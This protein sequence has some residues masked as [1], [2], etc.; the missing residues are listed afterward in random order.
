MTLQQIYYVLTISETGSMNQAAE[1]LFISQPAL[2][3]AIRELEEEVG[4]TIFNRSSRGVSETNEGTEFLTQARQLYQQYELMMEKYLEPGGIRRKFCVSAQH[5][6]FA[7]NA[8]VETVKRFD[9]LK[10]EYAIRETRTFD[11]ILDVGTSRSEIGI[12]YRN[13]FNRKM[14]EKYFRDY[15]LVFTPLV[16]C[17]P[18][19]YISR[20]HPLAQQKQITLK[21]LEPYPCLAFEQG[22][23]GSLFMAEELLSDHEYPRIIRACDRATMLNLMTGLNAYTLCSGIICQELNGDDFLAIPFAAPEESISAEMEIGYITRK[24]SVPSELGEAYLEEMKRYLG[25]QEALVI[26]APEAGPSQKA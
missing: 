9:L 8:F 12:L 16:K 20:Q 19:V 7:V 22:E 4:I 24:H 18:F 5:Y 21:Q 11:V 17:S 15:D 14:L 3:K 13:D 10:Y 25:G 23:N 26:T 2:T 6:S 1:R